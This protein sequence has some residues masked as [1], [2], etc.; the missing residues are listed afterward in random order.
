MRRNAIAVVLSLMLLSVCTCCIAGGLW[1]DGYYLP[2]KP[3]R[4][5]SYAAGKVVTEATSS[6]LPVSMDVVEKFYD[7]R[8]NVQPYPAEIGEWSRQ[9]LP[10]SRILYSC[11]AVDINR[12]SVET[13]CIYLWESDG[14]T[15]IQTMLL[16]SEGGTVPCP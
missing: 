13:G 4:P 2:Y 3:C 8:L 1:W 10:D 7:Q 16:R 9:K 12:L 6:I 11:P 15:H 5:I 14:N